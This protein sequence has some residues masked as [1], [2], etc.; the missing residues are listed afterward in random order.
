MKLAGKHTIYTRWTLYLQSFGIRTLA[1]IR[2]FPGSGKY[3]QFNKE[4]LSASLK[5]SGIHYTH[6]E[7]LGGRRK[8]HTKDFD[9]KGYTHYATEAGRNMKLKAANQIVLGA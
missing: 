9:Y 4:S 5:Q 8:V 1:D 3:P 2:R 7:D 6:L